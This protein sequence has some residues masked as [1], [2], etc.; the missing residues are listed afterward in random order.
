MLFDKTE[1]L[2]PL[3]YNLRYFVITY[4]SFCAS[5]I[6]PPS[7][8]QP[9]ESLASSHYTKPLCDMLLDLPLFYDSK[10]VHV[11]REIFKNDC[12]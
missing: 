6:W 1:I 7:P 3:W 9:R 2:T 11:I 8:T 5:K 4:V 12:I 10:Y